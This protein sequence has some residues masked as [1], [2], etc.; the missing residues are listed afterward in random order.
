MTFASRRHS[1]ALFVPFLL[2]TSI[3]TFFFKIL[4]NKNILARN[5]RKFVNIR[6]LDQVK[7]LIKMYSCQERLEPVNATNFLG[8]FLD[9]LNIELT[10]SIYMISIRKGSVI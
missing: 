2:R 8:P 7:I 6:D 4:L 5:L 10:K 9:M 3:N 1:D